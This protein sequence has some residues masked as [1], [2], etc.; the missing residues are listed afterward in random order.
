MYTCN[1]NNTKHIHALCF[2][3]HT[4]SFRAGNAPSPLPIYL[5]HITRRKFIFFKFKSLCFSLL[6]DLLS[7]APPHWRHGNIL[8][9]PVHMDPC[10][11]VIFFYARFSEEF[12]LVPE[13]THFIVCLPIKT[14]TIPLDVCH[15][16]F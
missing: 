3:P 8:A 10:A 7:L 15:L 12:C 16:N 5:L 11:H 1:D 9:V 14:I 2:P 4:G 13:Y 6:S